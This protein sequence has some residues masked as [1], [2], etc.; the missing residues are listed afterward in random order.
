M[1]WRFSYGGCLISWVKLVVWLLVHDDDGDHDMD[2]YKMS[3]SGVPK[4]QWPAAPHSYLRWVRR[5]I[6]SL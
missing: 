1:L 6:F 2:G 5:Y 3:G 4:L